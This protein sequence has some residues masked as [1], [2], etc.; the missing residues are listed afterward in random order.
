MEIVVLSPGSRAIEP[1]ASGGG[2]HPSATSM[3]GSSLN[4]SV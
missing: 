4:L 3:N 2:Q 1:M